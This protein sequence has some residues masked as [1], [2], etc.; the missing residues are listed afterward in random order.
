MFFFFLP[1]LRSR[2][3]QHRCFLSAAA[4]PS[5]WSPPPPP[6]PLFCPQVTAGKRWPV[7]WMRRL[8]SLAN[9]ALILPPSLSFSGSD[10]LLQ[11]SGAGPSRLW[12]HRAGNSSSTKASSH[13]SPHH[14]RSGGEVL[15]AGGVGVGHR[16]D[17]T[18]NVGKLIIDRGD[19][20]VAAATSWTGSGCCNI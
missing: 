5:S 7:V 12:H 18:G 14:Q 4:V 20:E 15:G 10:S 19:D 16:A 9:C 2:N 13:D 11:G 6:P 17:G 1:Q 3:E 8:S